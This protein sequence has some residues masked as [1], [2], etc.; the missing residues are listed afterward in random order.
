[1]E[2]RANH[3]LIG[4]FVL[5]IIAAAFSFLIWLAK[6]DI[7]RERAQYY[8]YFEESVSG[9]AIGGDVRFN[10]ILIGSIAGI[11]IDPDNPSRVRVLIDVAA[12]A[13]I[14]TDTKA[15]L[16]FKGITG[17]SFVQLIGGSPSEPLLQPKREGEIPVIASIPST[18]HELFAGAP[19]LIDRVVILINRLTL[20]VNDENQAHFRNILANVDDITGQLKEQ[21]PQIERILKNMDQMSTDLSQSAKKINVL[22]GKIETVLDNTDATLALARGTMS[23]A[24]QLLDQDVRALIGDL[25]TTAQ[26]FNALSRRVDGFL[27]KNSESLDVFAGQGL[28]EFTRFVEEARVLVGS[29]ERLLET[30]E[31]NPA[32]FLFGR[33]QGGVEPK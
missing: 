6:I 16:E 17:V 13:P 22:I 25:R 24:D 15:S 33:Q 30:L 28:V 2:T 4:A 14:R 9:L 27:D 8:I 29:T 19:E 7:E 26:G 12:D 11:T 10:G 32:Q 1:M 18:L 5:V 23:T 3:I 21:G 31:A 20:L